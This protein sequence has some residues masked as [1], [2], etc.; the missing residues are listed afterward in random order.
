MFRTLRPPSPVQ[1]NR[2]KSIPVTEELRKALVS[3]V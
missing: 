3:S 1:V 2:S